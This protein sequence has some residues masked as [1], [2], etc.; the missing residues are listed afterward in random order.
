MALLYVNSLKTDVLDS[1][2]TYSLLDKH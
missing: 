1:H 2:V